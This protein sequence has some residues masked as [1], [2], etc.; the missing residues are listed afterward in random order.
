M[1][2]GPRAHRWLAKAESSRRR[3]DDQ[4]KDSADE[5]GAGA[6]AEEE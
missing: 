6:D 3:T 5:L 1:T 2:E 4:R